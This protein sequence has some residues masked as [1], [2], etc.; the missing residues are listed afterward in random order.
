M[1][2]TSALFD[3]YLKCPTKCYLRSTGQAGSG[4]AY[5]EWVR[6]Q[7]EAYR[8]EAAQ[9]LMAALPD[10]ERAITMP[11][12]PNLRTATWRLAVD[13]P[14]QAGDMESRLQAVERVPSQGRGRPAQFI[15]VRF[16]FFNKLTKHDRL[17]LAFDALAL[18][19][20]LGREV[21]AGKIVHG[22]DHATLKLKIPGLLNATRR[23]I[24]DA[25]ALLAARSPPDRILNRH[26]GESEFR[27]GC[28][29]KALE[30]D[31]LSLLG[32]L[33]EK[34]RKDYA[35]KGIFTVRQLSYTFRPRRRPKRFRDKKEKYHHSLRALAI[36]ENKVYLVGEVDLKLD[37]TL[38]FLDVEG[39][40]DRD[41]YYLIGVRVG[42]GE[43][44]IQHSFWAD[45]PSEG[46]TIWHQFLETLGCLEN[47]VLVHYGSYETT[48]MKRMG[49]RYGLPQPDSP[50]GKAV[51]S[52]TNLLS[53]I[54]ARIYLPT[55][56][57]GLKEIAAWL[58]YAYTQKDPSGARAIE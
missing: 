21:S 36:R 54:F 58:G 46:R 29:Q 57:N 52:A 8:I 7:N 16:V 25:T 2:T 43:S 55:Y 44:A 27:D 33:T 42:T 10:G 13:L 3:A 4:N 50:A 30:K 38:V 9:R 35:S 28:R 23:L 53:Y 19:E 56:T 15:P 49:E 39:I 11:S 18:S 14:V 1:K 45:G 22:D 26:C 17:L 37:G 47:P 32:G 41:F 48:F 40:P 34:E 24:N 6:D 12:G 5:A 31:D 51:Q 20:V